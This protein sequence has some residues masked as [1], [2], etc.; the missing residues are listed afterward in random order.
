M[1]EEEQVKTV[2][3]ESMLTTILISILGG[4][5]AGGVGTLLITKNK[6]EPVEETAPPVV[7]VDDPVASGQQD[8]I[9]QVTS[10]DLVSVSCSKDHIDT[11]GD[12]LC[13]E[14]FCRLQQ[15]GIDAQTTGAECEEI[16][17]IANTI[18][19]LKACTVK[20]ETN[21]ENKTVNVFDEECSELFR[22]RK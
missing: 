18:Q 12:L 2:F 22:V 6:E 13:R 15:R 21:E 1:S 14:M 3:G 7:V 11:H 17:N 8:V 10:P 19:I 20:V 5:V 16:S 4:V 9:K